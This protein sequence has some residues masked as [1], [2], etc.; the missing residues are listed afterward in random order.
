MGGKEGVE[1]STHI[2]EW[3]A[4]A[5]IAH[6]HHRFAS[7][8][9]DHDLDLTKRVQG[10]LSDLRNQLLGERRAYEKSVRA[11][12]LSRNKLSS[13]RS[14]TYSSS[15]LGRTL[16]DLRTDL[17]LNGVSDLFWDELVD[18]HPGL[19][20]HFDNISELTR[21]AEFARLKVQ[22]R[23]ASRGPLLLK[24]LKQPMSR[25]LMSCLGLQLKKII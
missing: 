14:Q 15:L 3:N 13:I 19:M 9:L 7:L 18:K 11:A 20:H 17:R 2:G 5:R 23:R 12:E 4:A 22:T 10:V 24:S 21:E 16:N 6:L 8:A 25:T 1:H